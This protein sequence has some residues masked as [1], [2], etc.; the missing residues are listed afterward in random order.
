LQGGAQERVDVTLDVGPALMGDMVAIAPS[1]PLVRAIWAQNLDE[2][3]SLLAQGV[4]VDVYDEGVYMTALGAAVESGRIEFVQALLHA[5][6]DPNFRSPGGRAALIS[7]RMALMSLDADATP[8]IVRLLVASGAQVNLKDNDGNSALHSAATVA[9]VEVLRALLEAGA[10]VNARNGV[11]I[12]ALMCAAQHGRAD[13][14]KALLWAGA[15]LHM[16]NE[17]GV[18]ALKIAEGNEHQK[19]VAL[20][21]A[22]GAYE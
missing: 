19:V 22:H 5:G 13:I 1:T 16:K 8:E 17:G 3:R 9:K 4:E 6:A 11:G 18:T 21:R 2:V 14:V 20:L 7:G 12:T 15:D 10:V